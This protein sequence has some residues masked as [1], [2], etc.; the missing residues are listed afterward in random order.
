MRRA[1]LGFTLSLLTVTAFAGAGGGPAV[2]VIGNL[3]GVSPGAEGMLVLEDDE[4]V[5]RSGKVV[6]SVPYGDIRN[7]ELGTKV[8]PPTGVPLYKVWQ[9]HKRFL[10]E[11]P[12]HQMVNFDFTDKDGK[13]QTMTLEFEESAANET[14]VEIETRTGKRKRATNADSWWGDSAWKTTRNN[15]SVSPD[16]LGNSPKK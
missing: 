13:D 5:F 14:L 15:N 8:L 10:T 6:L 12:M 4:A 1:S 16:M 7:V 11:R 9:L 2:Y 3:G